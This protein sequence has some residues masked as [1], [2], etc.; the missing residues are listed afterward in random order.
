MPAPLLSL[1]RARLDVCLCAGVDFVLLGRVVA[2][3]GVYVEC[4]SNAPSTRVAAASLVPILR[5]A[6][7]RYHE[8]PFVRR[9]ARSS[10]SRQRHG[11]SVRGFKT[12]SHQHMRA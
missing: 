3:L 10:A 7:L 2:T 5:H 11:L 8:Q 6:S 1:D 4:A 12:E 9:S